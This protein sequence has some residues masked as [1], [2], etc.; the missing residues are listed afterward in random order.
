MIAVKNAD[1]NKILAKYTDNG[2]AVSSGFRLKCIIPIR[3]IVSKSSKANTKNIPESIS[4]QLVVKGGKIEFKFPPDA[5][6]DLINIAIALAP[7]LAEK[8]FDKFLKTSP[9]VDISKFDIDIQSMAVDVEMKTLEE[10]SI[11]DGFLTLKK[12]SFALQHKKGAGSWDFKVE[13]TQQIGESVLNVK[14]EK[15]GETFKLFGK[16]CDA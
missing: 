7:K 14:I 9:K 6:M 10:I 16:F 8:S 4:L 13:S 1:L 12:A 5:K 3:D 15:T 2:K 11:A